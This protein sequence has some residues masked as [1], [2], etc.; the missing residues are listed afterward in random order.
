V[1][2]QF[3]QGS[4]FIPASFKDRL[5]LTYAFLRYD[6]PRYPLALR[7]GAVGEY[8]APYAA[9]L[10]PAADLKALQSLWKTRMRQ[11][12][13]LKSQLLST[14]NHQSQTFGM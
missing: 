1:Q 3:V 14:V 5:G 10:P 9:F 11:L 2:S 12:K 4:W 7:V 13:W 6:W 8:R